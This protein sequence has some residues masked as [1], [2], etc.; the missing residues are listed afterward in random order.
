MWSFCTE[1]KKK[2]ASWTDNVPLSL[3]RMLPNRCA[4]CGVMESLLCDEYLMC[5]G[6]FHAVGNWP[7]REC[8]KTFIAAVQPRFNKLDVYKIQGPGCVRNAGA[9]C[10]GEPR[11]T[12][13]STI[14]NILG[15]IQMLTS[16]PQKWRA[17]WRGDC[18]TEKEALR[19]AEGTPLTGP[20][21][22]QQPP[23][24]AG[25]QAAET[26][27]DAC[28]IPSCQPATSHLRTHASV[29]DGGIWICSYTATSLSRC[30]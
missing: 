21:G 26:K 13:F 4:R 27:C 15:W 24:H 29:A 1:R 17:A 16:S 10:A 25:H 19:V 3:A 7:G 9:C 8:R 11:C 6:L 30:R 28:L 18:G 22:K 20:V 12:N 23:R 14:A 2:K 5:F